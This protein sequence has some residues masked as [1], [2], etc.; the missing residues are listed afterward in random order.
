MVSEEDAGGEAKSSRIIMLAKV[1]GA[2][3]L[4]GFWANEVV[5]IKN[6]EAGRMDTGVTLASHTT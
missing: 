1:P 3:W 2:S 5:E 6:L 4:F